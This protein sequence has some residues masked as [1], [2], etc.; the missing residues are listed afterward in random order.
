MILWL[1]FALL[2][3]VV[4]GLV[5][6]PIWRHDAGAKAEDD[7]L[8][9]LAV[10]RDQL[11]EIEHDLDRGLIGAQAGEAARSELARRIFS[12]VDGSGI[13]EGAGAKVSGFRSMARSIGSFFSSGRLVYMIAVFLP[14]T[15]VLLYVAVGSPGVKGHPHVAA[16][17]PSRALSDVENLVAQVEARLREKPDDGRGWDVVA[18]V[19]ARLGWFEDAQMAYRQALKLLGPSKER[20]MGL[21]HASIRANEGAI[22]QEARS[23]FRKLLTLEPS[24]IEARLWLARAKEQDG[25]GAGAVASYKDILAG[26]AE[27]A[28][29]RGLVE[30]RIAVLRPRSNSGGAKVRSQNPT[31]PSDGKTMAAVSKMSGAQKEKFINKMVSGLAAR[32]AQDGSDFDG[33]LRLVR[34]YVVLGRIK[35]ARKALFDARSHFASEEKRVR[36]LDALARKYRLGS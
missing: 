1:G 26:S 36:K 8:Y 33:W 12:L 27:D 28:P 19:Y 4:V 17:K 25:D 29:W 30:E 5:L 21:G 34:A 15:S 22:N 14:V 9:D 32:L 20:L 31:G 18:P 35:D 23:V 6:S 16:V 7:D 3:A 2:T 13:A 11:S 10:Y 24:N